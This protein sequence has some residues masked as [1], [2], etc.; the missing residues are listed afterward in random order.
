M[1]L[2]VVVQIRRTLHEP[3]GAW[4]IWS[5]EAKAIAEAGRLNEREHHQVFRVVPLLLDESR[6]ENIG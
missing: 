5:T 4:S 2:W 3:E 6:D 1:K